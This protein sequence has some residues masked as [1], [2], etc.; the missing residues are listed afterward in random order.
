[1]ER[2]SSAWG[3]G[4]VGEGGGLEQMAGM[5]LYVQVAAKPWMCV[6]QLV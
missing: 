4:W 6:D 2:A 5:E 3:W 1:M